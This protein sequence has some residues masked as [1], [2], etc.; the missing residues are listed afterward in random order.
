MT[1]NMRELRCRTCIYDTVCLVACS[2]ASMRQAFLKMRILN[3]EVRH[4]SQQ[5]SLNFMPAFKN[6]QQ[7]LHARSVDKLVGPAF[8]GSTINDT[9]KEEEDAFI[10]RTVVEMKPK[11]IVIV[12]RVA[13]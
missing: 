9:A 1:A 7:E 10:C 13:Q 12:G 5:L 11:A 3:F 2:P 8:L 4:S 6:Q